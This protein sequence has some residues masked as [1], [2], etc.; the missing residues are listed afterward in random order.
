MT[1]LCPAEKLVNP[2]ATA[3]PVLKENQWVLEIRIRYSEHIVRKSFLNNNTNFSTKNP[4]RWT[5]Y[6]TF[7]KS[8]I[9]KTKRVPQDLKYSIRMLDRQFS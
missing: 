6:F 2:K 1:G 9:I 7:G 5:K 3:S 4:L 8:I